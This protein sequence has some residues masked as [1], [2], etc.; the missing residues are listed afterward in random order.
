MEHDEILKILKSSG[1]KGV[2]GRFISQED[3]NFD[4]FKEICVQEGI[5]MTSFESILEFSELKL[6]PSGLIP[7][8]VQ[9]YKTN[10][11]LMLAYMN[12]EA[13]NHKMCIRDSCNRSRAA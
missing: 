4:G 2:S 13:F 1:V 9:D 10:E 6:N 5:K 11:V 7:V 8:L 12:K 3:M